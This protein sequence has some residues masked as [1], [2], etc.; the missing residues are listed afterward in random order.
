LF[1]NKQ[2]NYISTKLLKIGNTKF[3]DLINPIVD[4][5]K[6][7]KTQ[8]NVTDMINYLNVTDQIR[9][10][11]FKKNYQELSNLLNLEEI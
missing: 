1:N 6:K 5:M 11:D 4:A 7:R 3:N 9:R 8:C 2:K 10:Q